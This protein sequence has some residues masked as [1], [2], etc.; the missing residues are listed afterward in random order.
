MIAQAGKANLAE[1]N[2]M[3]T[4]KLQTGLKFPTSLPSRRQLRAREDARSTLLLG[5]TECW[6]HLA[7]KVYCSFNTKRWV[8]VWW[9]SLAEG[10]EDTRGLGPTFSPASSRSPGPA[11]FSPAP[12]SPA[13]PQPRTLQ[14]WPRI[15]PPELSPL[16][17]RCYPRE[18][19]EITLGFCQLFRVAPNITCIYL[20]EYYW[21]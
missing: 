10:E 4:V 13:S 8:V 11:P 17:T 21:R 18:P 9:E 2:E 15:P 7:L 16:Q 20:K 3:P 6:L 12:F 19:W 14:P 5:K 1:I